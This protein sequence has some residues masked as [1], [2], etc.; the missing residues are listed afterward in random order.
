MTIRTLMKVEVIID[1]L[2]I[3]KFVGSKIINDIGEDVFPGIVVP[4]YH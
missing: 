1:N 2:I 4:D 3:G